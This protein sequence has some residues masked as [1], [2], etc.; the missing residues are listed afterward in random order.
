MTDNND[1]NNCFYKNCINKSKYFL[2]N[3][4]YCGIHFKKYYN[5]LYNDKINNLINLKDI[6]NLKYYNIKFKKTKKYDNIQYINDIIKKNINNNYNILDKLGNGEFGS[7]YLVGNNVD[8]IF[9][10]KIVI[11][12][13]DKAKLSKKNMDILHS[14]H[15]I[16][17]YLWSYNIAC[18]SNLI[19]NQDITQNDIFKYK[20]EEYSY[21][22]LEYFPKTLSKKILEQLSINDIYNIIKQLLLSIKELHKC[23]Y[24]HN[25]LKPDNIMFTNENELKLIDF[26]LCSRFINCRGE[27]IIQKEIGMTG[28]ERYASLDALNRLSTSRRSDIE[29]IGYICI[30]LIEPNHKIFKFKNIEE[31]I[32]N[33]KDLFKISS[34]L[35][36]ELPTFLKQYFKEIRKYKY[37]NKPN[38]DYLISLF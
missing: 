29:S 14:E 3:N 33:K 28:N 38:Y 31:N 30:Y 37:I 9:A 26:G 27:H 25:D 22:I 23:N 4:E 2:E 11:Y 1:D 18:A 21:L 10:I 20:S 36:N 12:N 17:N 24:L 35:H 15:S 6:K 13:T 34:T 5:I 7:V 32:E 8:I 19:T 16:Y